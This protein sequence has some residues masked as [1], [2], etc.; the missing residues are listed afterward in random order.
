MVVWD[1]VAEMPPQQRLAGELAEAGRGLWIVMEFSARC[2]C[3]LPS[4]PPGGKVTR[5]LIAA[6]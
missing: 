4:A 2:D 1:A 6:P 5:A 3:Y